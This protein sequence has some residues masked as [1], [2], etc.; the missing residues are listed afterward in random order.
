MIL[1]FKSKYIKF[2]D[3]STKRLGVY[4]IIEIQNKQQEF[5]Q[6]IVINHEGLVLATKV[7]AINA[8]KGYRGYLP[9]KDND[10]E[11][12]AGGLESLNTKEDQGMLEGLARQLQ[13]KY[14]KLAEAFGEGLI[15]L[16]DLET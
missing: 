16:S 13:F 10:L 4:C 1:A 11:F 5:I 12:G 6:I 15:K 8:I 14:S 7:K 3:E 2:I 9:I